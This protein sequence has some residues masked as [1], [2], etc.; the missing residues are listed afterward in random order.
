MEVKNIP[1][2]IGNYG[3]KGL[4]KIEVQAGLLNEIT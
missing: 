2:P 3:L 1:I 4:T